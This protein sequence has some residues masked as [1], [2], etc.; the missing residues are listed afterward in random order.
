MRIGQS[1]KR[2]ET[3]W[4]VITSWTVKTDWT[5]K[6]SWTVKA[7]WTVTFRLADKADNE[8]SHTAT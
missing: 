6:T 2:I 3:D 1:K 8:A 5:V 7:S 4:T